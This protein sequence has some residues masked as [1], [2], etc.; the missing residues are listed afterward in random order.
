VVSAVEC[1]TPYILPG[2]HSLRIVWDN[3]ESYTALELVAVHVQIGLGPD[4]NGNGIKDWV[5]QL[6]QTQSGMDNTNSVIGSYTSPL[7]L[8]GR[9][10]YPPLMQMQAGSSTCHCRPTSTPRLWLKP[11]I[12]A[13][14]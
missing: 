2:P 7:C 11:A 1:W 14:H 5:D 6:V 12:R 8:E 10:P 4:E 3:A 13:A 9:D